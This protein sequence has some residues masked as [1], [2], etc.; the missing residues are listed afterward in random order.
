MSSANSALQ[1]APIGGIVTTTK[2]PKKKTA[3][4]SAKTNRKNLMAGVPVL[5]RSVTGDPEKGFTNY[6]Y[7]IKN[8]GNID[9][10]IPYVDACESFKNNKNVSHDRVLIISDDTGVAR[11]VASILA[12]IPFDHENNNYAED[13][14]PISDDEFFDFDD[15]EIEEEYID[16]EEFEE[17]MGTGMDARNMFREV[18][19]TDMGELSALSVPNPYHMFMQAGYN[20]SPN[21]YV[22]GLE[23]EDCRKEKLASLEALLDISILRLM[24][25]VPSA[26]KDSLW[27]K[28]LIRT[29]GFSIL[30]LPDCTDYMKG[31]VKKKGVT[32]DPLI[33]KKAI[34]RAITDRGRDITEEDITW[35]LTSPSATEGD[36]QPAIERLNSMIGLSDAKTAAEEL[37]AIELE[38]VRNPALKS[39]RKHMLFAGNPGSGKTTTAEIMSKILSETGNSRATFVT[40][41]RSDL[42]GKYVGHTAP[43]VAKKFLEAKGGILFVDE[44]GFF[45][46]ENR[47]SGFTSEAIR[48]FVRYMELYEDVTVIFAMYQDEVEDFLNLDEG[49]RSRICRQV[50]F[51]DYTDDELIAI[52]KSMAEKQGYSFAPKTAPIITDYLRRLRDTAG[53]NYGNARE[54]RKVV[55]SAIIK[56]AIRMVR[57]TKGS[58]DIENT[59]SGRKRTGTKT[60]SGSDACVLT[61]ADVR[62]GIARL[63][64]EEKTIKIPLGFTARAQVQ[65][66]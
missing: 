39:M 58:D 44:A 1:S 16:M 43:K 50:S 48:E 42:I 63:E 31:L 6:H 5:K 18:S 65:E 15:D 52:A 13:S 56:H 51:K 26:E 66:G 49:L 41:S 37:Y 35:Y 29:M 55:E 59:T 54:V 24:I 22:T 61:V 28:D 2:T 47:T 4:P 25:L 3:M 8:L 19:F 33:A 20:V 62:E 57:S 32:I 30:E 27:V 40:V 46:S 60:A 7:Q 21:L 10:S 45:L 14:D 12:P 9:L 64:P 34:G 17:K 36:D 11:K 38:K 23:D 53:N